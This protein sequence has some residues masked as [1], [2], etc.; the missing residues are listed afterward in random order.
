MQRVYI[1]KISS[2]RS[3]RK[4]SLFTLIYKGRNNYEIR[5]KV[6]NSNLFITVCGTYSYHRTLKEL[7]QTLTEE[8]RSTVNSLKVKFLF[9]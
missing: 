5:K 7:N 9:K 3:F 6:E 4:L 1:T 2:I 8:V